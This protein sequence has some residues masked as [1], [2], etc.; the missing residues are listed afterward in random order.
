MKKILLMIIA[1]GLGFLCAYG[2]GHQA[3]KQQR[4]AFA[5]VETEWKAEKAG[6]ETA[7][8]GAKGQIITLPGETKT[9]Q[10]EKQ[11]LSAEIIERLKT[12]K[13]AA[14]NPR[15]Q[16]LLIHQFENLIEAGPTAVP[17]I[18]K[19]LM[20]NIDVDYDLSLLNRSARDGRMPAG[21]NVPP[22]LRLGLF[23]ALKDIGGTAAEKTLAENLSVTGRGMEVAYLARIL[24]EMSPG[25]YRDVALLAA[26]ELLAHPLADDKTDRNF[27]LT[28]LAS[29][30]DPSFSDQARAQ[31]IQPDGK[32]DTAA[33]KYLQQT[34]PDKALAIAMQAYQDQRLT[35]G[36]AK[37]RLAQVSLDSA[38]LDA[39]ADQFFK[40]ALNDPSISADGRRNLAED[41]ADHG[42]NAKNPSARDFQA[43]QNRFGQLDQL[44][45]SAT[46]PLVVAGLT[47]ARK[48]LTKSINSYRDQHPGQ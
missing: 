15:S 45:A 8:A 3:L 14:N 2:L 16:R 27:L 26:H 33:L 38:G 43:M 10:V 31:L 44:M 32:V 17:A 11:I 34:Q 48:D 36:Q 6:L 25:K 13:L 46:D 24:E 7:L 21:F 30:N 22:S 39:N 12:M 29:L 19:F 4:A 41:F 47:E 18:R 37:E 42:V 40:M 20:Q 23:E 9:V 5:Q 28:T 1:G 35:D